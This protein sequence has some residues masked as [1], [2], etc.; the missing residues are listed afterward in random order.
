M[1]FEN[2]F[3]NIENGVTITKYSSCMEGCGVENILHSDNKVRNKKI[4]NN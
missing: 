4:K 2:N 3:L 1:K